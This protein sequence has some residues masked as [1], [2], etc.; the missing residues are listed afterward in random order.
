M[1][2]KVS[3]KIALP[4]ALARQL[5]ADSVVRQ[6]VIELGLKHWRVRQALEAYRQGHG[7]L[8]HAAEQAGVSLREMIS[9]AYAYGLEPKLN[10]NWLSEPLTIDEA[11]KL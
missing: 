3:V 1:P 8:A 2:T 11:A 4:S 5:P 6:Q 10:S 9:M 7:T